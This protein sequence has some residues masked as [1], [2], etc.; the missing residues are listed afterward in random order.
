MER[1]IDTLG[2][3]ISS[4]EKV[5]QIKGKRY[6][7]IEE[8]QSYFGFTY[9]LNSIDKR[10]ELTVPLTIE[11]DGYPATYYTIGE[12]IFVRPPDISIISNSAAENFIEL[13]KLEETHHVSVDRYR[14]KMVLRKKD[15]SEKMPS[16]ANT[17]E[18]MMEG[19]GK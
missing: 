6:M 2:K 13:S 8:A 7:D 10:I 19:N 12:K 15:S 11:I 1:L 9:N 3:E 17:A 18:Q 4:K 16:T 14:T 5:T